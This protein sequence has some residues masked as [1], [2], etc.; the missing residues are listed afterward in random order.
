MELRAIL[1]IG[2]E[3]SRVSFTVES[4]TDV[5]TLPL[6]V[7]QLAGQY[8]RHEPVTEM[9]LEASI[10]AIEDVLLNEM[11]SLRRPSKLVT[12]DP[13]V[14]AIA[15]AAGM[16]NRGSVS[17]GY[18]AVERVY[19][20]LVLVAHGRPAAREGIPEGVAFAAKLLILREF[21][22]HVGHASIAVETGVGPPNV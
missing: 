14:A 5:V 4:Q 19:Q 21:M 3:Q 2:D 1:D 17:L 16:Q 20:R 13:D 22:A 12:A 18:E 9:E 8:L 15:V 10:T 11:A 7:R 6:G